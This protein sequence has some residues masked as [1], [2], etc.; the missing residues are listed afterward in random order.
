MERLRRS[1]RHNTYS[2]NWDES[3]PPPQDA[4]TLKPFW[5]R[6]SRTFKI[7][8]ERE[9]EN[10]DK[11]INNWTAKS[12]QGITDKEEGWGVSEDKSLYIKHIS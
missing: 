3:T 1:S 4:A 2:L 10:Q 8:K 9:T 5:K 6:R 11:G 12:K 7:K